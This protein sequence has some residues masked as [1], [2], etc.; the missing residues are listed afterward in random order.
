MRPSPLISCIGTRLAPAEPSETDP[1][2][3]FD[4]PIED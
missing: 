2:A 4:I 1:P 3:L